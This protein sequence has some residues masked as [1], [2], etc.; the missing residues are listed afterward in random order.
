[1]LLLTHRENNQTTQ[2]EVT[3]DKPTKKAVKSEN[4]MK[5]FQTEQFEKTCD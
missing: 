1:V 4:R 3:I 2:D 5:K